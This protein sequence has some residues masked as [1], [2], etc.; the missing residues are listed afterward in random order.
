MCQ[1][2]YLLA[3]AL[4]VVLVIWVCSKNTNRNGFKY[5]GNGY[6]PN[7]GGSRGELNEE[8]L[9]H[10]GYRMCMLTDGTSGV[11]ALSGMCVADME[12]DLRRERDS[13][14]RPLCTPPVFKEGCERFCRCQALLG[15]ECDDCVERCRSWF[16]PL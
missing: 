14:P 12:V 1:T 16:S 13:V 4:A 3:L 5:L 15:E 11:C 7:Q 9:Q 8:C 10:P 6:N 2:L